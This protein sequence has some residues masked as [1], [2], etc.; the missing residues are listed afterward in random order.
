MRGAITPTTEGPAVPARAAATNL[1]CAQVSA[2]SISATPSAHVASAGPD[3]S[4]TALASTSTGGTP[5]TVGAGISVANAASGT[6]AHSAYAISGPNSRRAGMRSARTTKTAQ[7]AARFTHS[8]SAKTLLV[9]GLQLRDQAFQPRDLLGREVAV[10]GVVG[11]QRRD[12]A[13][14]QPV[15]QPLALAGDILFAADD[16]TV[17]GPAAAAFRGQRLLLQEP[18]DQRLDGGL[19]PGLGRPDGLDDL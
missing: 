7:A 13:A 3:Q 15:Q 4:P 8:R 18:V 11:D 17:H 5:S 1:R 14:E 10:A 2:A 12:L 6:A 16:G 19:A 9:I